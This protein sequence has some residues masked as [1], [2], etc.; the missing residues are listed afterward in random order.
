MVGSWQLEKVRRPDERKR[1]P[2][3]QS[4]MTALE[5]PALRQESLQAPYPAYITFVVFTAN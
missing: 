4:R 5:D 1:N 2:A 3:T